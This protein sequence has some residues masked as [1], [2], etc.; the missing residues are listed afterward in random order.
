M[1]DN[2]K[3]QNA[4]AAIRVSTTS[5]GTDGD[6][7]EAQKEQIE[8]YVASRHVTIKKFFVF[9][10]S[11]SKE[12]QPMQ[13][14]IDYCKD[15]K[16]G[17][18]LFIIKSIDRFTRGGSFSYDTL[19]NQLDDCG[20]SLVDIYGVISNTKINTLEHLG[21][22]Y[23]WS[24]YSPTK[25]AEMLEAERAK[26][27]VRDILSRMVG[28]EIRYARMGYWVRRAPFGC[29]NVKVE[30]QNGKRCILMPHPTEA[31][32]II[33]MFELRARGTHDDRQIVEEINGLGYRS[34][35]DLV[36]DKHDRTKI[37]RQMGG[38]QLDVKT[39][40]R[41]IHN[42]V[43]AGVNPEKWTEGKPVKC[44][45]DGL[46]SIE[47]FNS[48]NKGKVYISEHAGEVS[49][50]IREP[51]KYLIT[52]GVKN[53]E[54]PYKK[55]VMCP[56]CELP[57][58]GSASRG[59]L[60]KHYG[61]Y[62]CNRGHYFRVPKQKFDEVVTDYIK[63]IHI[64]PDY[65]SA[66][67]TA[68]LAEWERRQAELTQDDQNLDGRIAALKSQA[69]ALVSKITFLTSE[70]AI[71]YMEEELV[72]NETQIA[73]L[74][75]QKEEIINDKPIDIRRVMNYVKYFVEHLE[76]LLLQQMNP[77]A[78]AGF[79]GVLFDVPPTYAELSGLGT[80][81]M[82][83]ALELNNL[84]EHKNTDLGNLAGAAGFEPANAST[85]NWCLTTW[86]RPNATD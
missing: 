68:V 48:A 31:P 47:L 71:K 40:W 83:P 79:F 20:V 12:Q 75:A 58:Y 66:L 81:K 78:R 18:N 35:V 8:R 59:K 5:Q 21:V 86:P 55:Q 24:E 67:E 76:Y 14:A 27:E 46:V 33:K 29:E 32:F 36:R 37:I 56:H 52:K 43:Y 82:T 16:N 69:E 39:L 7:P 84:F 50:V 74:T 65:M 23:K 1:H 70:V 28:A 30:T 73:E 51:A 64:S 34:R 3:P 9:L 77:V 62:H 6:S 15:P 57:L 22:K 26:D 41:Y 19:K 54:Y 61:A 80:P 10:E 63:T 53:D 25:K 11:A 44:K 45:F 13:E 2:L 38:K 72:K 49:I 17:I 42:P 60:G 4:V 85:K